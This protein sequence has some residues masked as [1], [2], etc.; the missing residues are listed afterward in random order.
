MS[1]GVYRLVHPASGY[2][3]V[4]ASR[5]LYLRYA[6]W[7]AVIDRF[8][9]KPWPKDVPGARPSLKLS[10]AMA[11]VGADGW[12]IGAVQ[13]YVDGID[14]ELLWFAECQ[15]IDAVYAAVGK[16]RCLNSVFEDAPAWARHGYRP[17]YW[18]NK[19]YRR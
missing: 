13:E 4:G 18:K 5:K 15:E 8:R 16:D 7:H 14:G 6:Q 2:V 17:R 19:P 3:Y 1:V 9:G 10:R 11:E 12:I